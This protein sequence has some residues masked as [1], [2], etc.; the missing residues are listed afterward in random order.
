MMWGLW[1]C[2]CILD[3]RGNV[4]RRWH[5]RRTWVEASFVS[6]RMP[7]SPQQ[8]RKRQGTPESGDV[9]SEN[10]NTAVHGIPFWDSNSKTEDVIKLRKHK[11][12]SWCVSGLARRIALD[13]DKV[14]GS[15][16]E[17]HYVLTWP[18]MPPQALELVSF[19]QLGNFIITILKKLP[20]RM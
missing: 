7:W 18:V 4:A 17:T 8:R 13:D 11:G 16:V 10:D 5:V 20:F 14:C 12:L 6:Y 9:L 15:T 2:P 1:L 19:A 3:P